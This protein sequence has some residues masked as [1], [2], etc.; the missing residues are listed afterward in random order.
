MEQFEKFEAVKYKKIM[1][2]NK[3]DLIVFKAIYMF[4]FECKL[5]KI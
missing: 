2:T 5:R 4:R 1:T 3:I